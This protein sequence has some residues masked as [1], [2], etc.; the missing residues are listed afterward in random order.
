MVL[1][2]PL[3]VHYLYQVIMLAL[4]SEHILRFF[5]HRICKSYAQRYRPDRCKGIIQGDHHVV[6][7]GHLGAVVCHKMRGQAKHLDDYCRNKG[8]LVENKQQH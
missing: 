1:Q 3:L 4:K 7:I 5:D 8:Y 6:H 2:L